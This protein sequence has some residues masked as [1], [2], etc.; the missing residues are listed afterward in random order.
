MF[1]Q[2]LKSNC[3]GRQSNACVMRFKFPLIAEEPSN[4]QS[5]HAKQQIHP[6][7]IAAAA[8]GRVAAAA[9]ATEKTI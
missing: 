1:C 7:D 9:A 6:F 3:I 2:C 5:S 4:C 8:A